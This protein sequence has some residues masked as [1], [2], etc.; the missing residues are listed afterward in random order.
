MERGTYFLL[1]GPAAGALVAWILFWSGYPQPLAWT[2]GVTVWVAAWWVFE[3]VPIPATSLIPFALL[4]LGGVLTHAQVANAY[5]HT[6]ILLLMAGFI[7]S[8]A[9]ES[10]GA[11]RRLALTLVRVIGRHSGRR[12]VLGF[13]VASAMLSMWIS[14]SATAL[15]LLPVALAVLEQTKQRE[16]LAVPL[17]LGLA[18]GA[19]IGGI[20]TPIGTPP[21]VIFMALFKEYTGQEWTF[22]QWM[23]IGVPIVVLLVPA[24]WWLITRNLRLSEALTV[25]HPGPW[26]SEERRVLTVFGVSALLWITRTEPWGGWNAWVETVWGFERQG[27]ETLT[28]DSTVALMMS[29][30]MFV[31]PDGHG[32][33]LLNWEAAKKLPWGL[34]LLFSGGLAIGMAFQASG[35][36]QE[37][38]N[39]LSGV[40]RWNL[41]L[42]I[43]VVCVTVT[44][45]T[46]IT[47]NTATTNI[48]LPI[49]AGACIDPDGGW[50]ISPELLMVPAA[51]SASCAFMLPVATAP[52][53][54]VFGTDQLTTRVMCRHGLAVNLVGAVVVTLICYWRLA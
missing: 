26:R 46:E 12:I 33:R 48:L 24:A 49:L 30:V 9:M 6:L 39:L 1:S 40:V 7:L 38:G 17:L 52:N 27:S 47:S 53:A 32:R 2:A 18:Y 31:T 45:L 15:M 21:N 29:L 42:V 10:S 25:P 20:G 37:I 8:T 41:L 36:S 43:A 28:G 44:F 3:P 14:N 4:P 51:I 35:L 5:G 54:I 19:N 34:L 16:A 50:L 11:H 22:L 13:M 23:Q